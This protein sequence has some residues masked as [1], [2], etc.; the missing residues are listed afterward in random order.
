[1]LLD[2]INAVTQA[3]AQARATVA[4]AEKQAEEMLSEARTAGAR[5]VE[6]A[7]KKAEAKLEEL[8][9]QI[10]ERSRAYVQELDAGQAKELE[11]LRRRA[12]YR[13]ERAV[14]LLLE[15]VEEG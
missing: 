4:A 8:A 12:D 3:E 7:G 11:T 2:A 14:A 1:M 6:K 13:M 9:R 5:A 10:D 15:R